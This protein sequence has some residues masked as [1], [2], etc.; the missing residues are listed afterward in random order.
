MVKPTPAAA[1][2]VVVVIFALEQTVVQEL[3]LSRTLALTQL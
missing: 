2:A 3:L 1:E